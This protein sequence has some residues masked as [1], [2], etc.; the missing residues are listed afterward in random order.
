MADPSLAVKAEAIRTQMRQVRRELGEDVEGL[1]DNA[2]VLTD[3]RYY[4]RTYPWLCVGAAAAVG[5]LIVPSRP[6]VV[7]PD[8]ALMAE[9]ARA[10]KVVVTPNA[11]PPTKSNS[12]AGS[13]GSLIGNAL[14][15]AGLT[16]VKQQLSTRVDSYIRRSHVAASNGHG[17]D[18]EP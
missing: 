12:L 14:L 9:L 13:L 10:R 11:D 6:Q 7:R 5:F 2:Q 1:V 18:G 16:L 17:K 8:P 4:V 3:W 15:H